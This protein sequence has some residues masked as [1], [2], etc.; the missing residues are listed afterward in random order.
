MTEKRR[1]RWFGKVEHR[2]NIDWVKHCMT[3]KVERIRQMGCL[4]KTWQDGVMMESLGPGQQDV[5]FRNKRR[6]RIK[7]QL[8]NPG[9]PEKMAIKTVCIKAREN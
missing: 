1:L 9:P 3:L 7:G 2:D 5:Q 8:A 6:L 4:K